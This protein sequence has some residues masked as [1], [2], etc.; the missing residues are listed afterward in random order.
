MPA[1]NKLVPRAINVQLV[2]VDH[3]CWVFVSTVVPHLMPRK[4]ERHASSLGRKGIHATV[5]TA[6]CVQR[7]L[8]VFEVYLQLAEVDEH[9]QL[10]KYLWFGCWS[11]GL[12][13]STSASGSASSASSCMARSRSTTLG[14]VSSCTCPGYGRPCAASHCPWPA[15]ARMKPSSGSVTVKG[16]IDAPGAAGAPWRL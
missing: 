12:S 3:L 11:P 6:L 2:D 16:C 1:P 13:A 9:V 14:G 7:A 8:H 10:E 4:H 5:Q 15:G